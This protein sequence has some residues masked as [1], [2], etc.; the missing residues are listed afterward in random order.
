MNK[1][2]K[3]I[4]RICLIL[5]IVLLG[6]VIFKFV[7]KGND[8]PQDDVTNNVTSGDN[9]KLEEKSIE[10]IKKVGDIEISN[11]KIT[12]VQEEESKITANVKNTSE[13]D[14]EATNVEIKIIRNGKNPDIIG[15]IIP[16]LSANEESTFSVPVL[17]NI[18]D[19]DDVEIVKISEE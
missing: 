12:L 14:I 17:A 13:N 15:G 5:V 3:I 8:L 9:F 7:K 19:A 4:L 16:A 10:E 2:K 6:V 1:K 18:V 11:I